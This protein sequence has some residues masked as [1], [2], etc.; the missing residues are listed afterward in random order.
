MDREWN[1]QINMAHKIPQR[2]NYKIDNY[3]YSLMIH[4]NLE[5]VVVLHLYI[6]LFLKLNGRLKLIFLLRFWCH[7]ELIR[8]QV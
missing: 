3:D 4:F 5:T 1:L 2:I 8:I 7:V 6:L